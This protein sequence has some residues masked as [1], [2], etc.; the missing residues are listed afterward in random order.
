MQ[1]W[2]LLFTALFVVS[3]RLLNFVCTD[4]ALEGDEEYV[5]LFMLGE[6][7]VTVYISCI[8]THHKFWTSVQLWYPHS[9]NCSFSSSYHSLAMHINLSTFS[10]FWCTFTITLLT[11]KYSAP[12]SVFSAPGSM[13]GR[14]CGLASQGPCRREYAS[15]ADQYYISRIVT[16]FKLLSS[17]QLQCHKFLKIFHVVVTSNK[18]KQERKYSERCETKKW[19]LAPFAYARHKRHS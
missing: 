12:N 10:L 9:S 17:Q 14:R 8:G 5:W 7:I 4:W 11:R 16:A 18:Q 1:K 2:S 15:K 6:P 13:K 19:R 3:L